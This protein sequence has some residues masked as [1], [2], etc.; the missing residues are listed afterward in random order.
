MRPD[1]LS[2]NA[3]ASEPEEARALLRALGPDALSGGL[4]GALDLRGFLV[5]AGL[6]SGRALM[7]GPDTGDTGGFVP[8]GADLPFRIGFVNDAATGA[9]VSEVRVV[10]PIDPALDAGSLALGGIR[11]GSLSVQP[12]PGARLFQRDIDL[13]ASRGFVLRV[14]AGVDT[15]SATPTATW[16]IQAIDPATGAP[17][18]DGARGLLLPG[19]TGEIGFALRADAADVSGAE[20]NASARVILDARLPED[21]RIDAFRLD[22]RAPTTD[23]A[24][25]DLGGGLF[26]LRWTA[27]D[28]VA[29]GH[30]TLYAAAPGEGFRII[31]RRNPSASGTFVFQGTP[32]TGY[33]F[34]AL[35]TDA[36]GNREAPRLGIGAPADGAGPDFGTALTTETTRADPPLARPGPAP[37]NPLFLAALA[38]GDPYLADVPPAEF[39]QVTRPFAAEAFA[40]GF[41]ATSDALGPTA[42]LALASGDVWIAGGTGRN[43]LWRVPADHD[44]AAVGTAFGTRSMRWRR[45]RRGGYGR[46]RGAA[47]CCRSIR[48]R[49]LCWPNMARAWAL[50]WRCRPSTAAS[51]SA[52]RMACIGSIPTAAPSA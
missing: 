42:L 6:S 19:E 15:L 39:A 38:V 3:L 32:G 44:G 26:E 50:R 25:A 12:P 18:R 43:Q 2:V 23:L 40:T 10:A 17:L 22:A 52:R 24:V 31:E 20:I 36:A 14:S 11:L 48:C 37:T 47:R 29:L 41:P 9:P 13:T 45:T 33:E 34:L 28:D 51:S 46:R 16:L 35:A 7:L 8:A 30:V 5:D 1:V 21:A 49:G 27:A 4:Q